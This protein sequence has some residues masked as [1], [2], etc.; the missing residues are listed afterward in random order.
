MASHMANS[1]ANGLAARNAAKHDS[2]VRAARDIIAQTPVESSLL[3][4]VRKLLNVNRTT[5]KN[6]LATGA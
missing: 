5:Q 2:K 6:L 3:K 4:S 1:L